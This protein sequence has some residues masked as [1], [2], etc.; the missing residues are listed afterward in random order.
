[1]RSTVSLSCT[2]VSMMMTVGALSVALS[3]HPN[4]ICRC[5][6][7]IITQQWQPPPVQQKAIKHLPHFKYDTISWCAPSGLA[8]KDIDNTRILSPSPSSSSSFG[9]QF[10][11][12]NNTHGDHRVGSM[13]SPKCPCH[14]RS[15]EN[16]R[17]KSW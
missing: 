11:V 10:L 1:V 6:F 5:T 14:R 3:S 9:S 8:S 16:M 13:L 12:A 2:D 17:I 15:R 7:C 4:S